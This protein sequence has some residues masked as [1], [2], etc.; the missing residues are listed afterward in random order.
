MNSSG[1]K[2][3]SISSSSPSSDEE[4]KRRTRVNL[5]DLLGS[6]RIVW[7]ERGV[8]SQIQ[9]EVIEDAVDEDGEF[10]Q[11]NDNV[12]EGQDPSSEDVVRK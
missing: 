10:D 1:G 7:P 6:G 4:G 5:G 11:E 8:F 2:I 12:V 3:I 9:V